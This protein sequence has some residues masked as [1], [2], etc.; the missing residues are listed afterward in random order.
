MGVGPASAG[1]RTKYFRRSGRLPVESIRADRLGAVDDFKFELNISLAT[2]LVLI[3]LI[4]RIVALIV[5]P[6]RA[7][8][9]DRRWRGCC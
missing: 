7:P 1:L 2:V 5:V 3:D 8:P 9:P 4:T 6:P